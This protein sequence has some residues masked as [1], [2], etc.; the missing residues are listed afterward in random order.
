[1]KYFLGNGKVSITKGIVH[2]LDIPFIKIAILEKQSKIGSDLMHS[3]LQEH[4]ETTIY[5]KNLEG[6]AVLEKMVKE[7]KKTL[8]KQN[9]AIK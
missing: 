9:K 7:V 5:V 8:K 4:S 1:M 3:D 2:E 6:L